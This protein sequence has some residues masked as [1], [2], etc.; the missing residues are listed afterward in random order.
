[1]STED[2]YVLVVIIISTAV[3]ML[4]GLFTLEHYF[5]CLFV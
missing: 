2:Y 3:V 1:M 5:P 4:A